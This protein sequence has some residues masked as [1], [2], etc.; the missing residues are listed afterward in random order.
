MNSYIVKASYL[1][2][3]FLPNVFFEQRVEKF[4]DGCKKIYDDYMSLVYPNKTKE[5]FK[6]IQGINFYSVARINHEHIVHC[7]LDVSNGDII[8]MKNLFDSSRRVI[9]NIFDDDLGLSNMSAFGYK[10]H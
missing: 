6:V 4:V 3:S 5:E 10:C 7:S 9:G 2:D 1:G 8:V